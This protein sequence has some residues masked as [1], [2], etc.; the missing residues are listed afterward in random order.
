MEFVSPPKNTTRNRRRGNAAVE[1]ALMLPWLVFTFAAVLDFGYCAYALI[2]TQNAARVVAMW[3]AVNSANASAMSSVAC[4]YAADELRYAPTPVTG[5]GT[6][7]SVATSSSTIT[8]PSS[9]TAVSVSVTY[10][11]NL[12]AIPGIMPN[13]L[14]ITRSVQL[15]VRGS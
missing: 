1:V 15:P 14:A 2:A 4:S 5:C 7:L 8:G 3:G 6:S 10:T 11:V 13:T 12:L 9:F